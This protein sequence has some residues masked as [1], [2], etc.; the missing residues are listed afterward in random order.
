MA[1][2]T[3][4]PIATTTLGTAVNNFTFSSIP[5]TYTDLRLVVNGNVAAAINNINARFNS[6][7]GSNYS[8]TNVGIRALSTTPFSGRDSQTYLGL[9]WYTAW[10]SAQQSMIIAD[11][12]N[13]AN[14]NVYKTSISQ[15][16]TQEG[17]GT[18]SGIENT[19]GT[20]RSTAAINSIY[21][22][23]NNTNN[24]SVGTTFTLYGIK[25]A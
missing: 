11:F 17:D 1:T 10:T 9:C 16:I 25:A 8:F 18:Y 19:V 5:S 13:Y 14:T 6:D 3:Y 22:Y 21:L 23:T 15:N 24:F 4:T 12:L 7:S 20:W 2:A